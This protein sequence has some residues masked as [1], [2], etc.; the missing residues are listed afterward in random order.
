MP[1]WCANSL[2]LVA[3]TP[4]SEKKLAEI[5]QE[6]ARAKTAGENPVIFGL[7]KPVPEALMITAGYL[8]DTV[9]Q[10]ALVEKEKENLKTYGYKNW[11]DFCIGEWGTK[12]DA[13]TEYDESYTI[14]GNQ[15]TIFFDTAWAPPMQIYYALEEMGFEVE[16]TYVEQGVGYIGFYSDGVD[17]CEK[18]EQFYP[19]PTDDPDMEDSA[20]DEITLKIYDYFEKNGFKHSPSN[21]GG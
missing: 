14:E 10:A 4:D 21:L 18:M 15:L 7:I 17:N 8:G 5:V 6:L 20:M 3:T 1:N 2:K 11:Y 16:A 13:K 12:W 19:E 9:E